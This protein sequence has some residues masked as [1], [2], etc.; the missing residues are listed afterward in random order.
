MMRTTPMA[1]VATV[2]KRIYILRHRVDLAEE[3]KMN[4]HRPTR[5][6]W[7]AGC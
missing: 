7:R 6:E 5:I 3:K 4:T 2:T 1:A